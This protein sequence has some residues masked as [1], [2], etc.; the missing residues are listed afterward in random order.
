M[1]LSAWEPWSL[2]AVLAPAPHSAEFPA[3]TQGSVIAELN[4]PATLSPADLAR[5]LGEEL[6][7][8]LHFKL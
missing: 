4:P 3:P 5:L 2:E 7:P 6:A 8:P 1:T